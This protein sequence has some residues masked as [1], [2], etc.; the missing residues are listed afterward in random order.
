M[1]GSEQA[2]GTSVP[3]G[4]NSSSVAIV[5]QARSSAGGFDYGE[6]RAIASPPNWASQESTQ[7]YR[8]A[9]V[10]NEPSTAEA[11]GQTWKT[12]GDELHQAANDLYN[13]IVE[14]GNVWIGQGAGAAQG[15]LVGIANSSQQAGD[16]AHTMANRMTQQAAAAAEVKKMPAPKEF[17]PAKQT[18]AMLAGGPAAMVADMKQQADAAKAVHEQQVQYFNAYTQAMSE[19]D[20]ATPSF[21]PESLGLPPNGALGGATHASSVGAPASLPGAYGGGALGP[22]TGMQV[23]GADVAG[24]GAAF[25]GHLGDL[26]QAAGVGAPGGPG[27]VPSP[28]PGVLSDAGVAPAAQAT[29]VASAGNG[30]AAL[31]VGLGLAGAGLGAA[32]GKAALGRGNKSGARQNPDETAAA[33]TDQSQ[34]GHS[35]AGAIPQQPIMSSNGTIGGTNTPPPAGMGGMGAGGAQPQEDEEHNRASY[36]V[37]ADPDEAFGANVATAPPVIGAW[38]D[39][40]EE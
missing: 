21:G 13:A 36:L 16:A 19:V 24:R 1:S 27:A 35:A 40:D 22:A 4:D 5:Q 25:S 31:G 34:Q 23:G 10:N 12:H 20:D 30:G 2:P 39:E 37:E 29:P 8:G 17:D 7:L 9:T 18:A 38:V 11:T 33:S 6:D 28:A 26:G 15:A 3:M 14:L 32:A